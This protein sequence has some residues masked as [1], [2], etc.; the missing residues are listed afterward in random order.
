MASYWATFR[1]KGAGLPAAGVGPG[2]N[3]GGV[4]VIVATGVFPEAG[5]RLFSS[6]ANVKCSLLFSIGFFTV[7]PWLHFLQPPE[8]DRPR[9]ARSRR[10]DEDFDVARQGKPCQTLGHGQFRV[11]GSRSMVP[12]RQITL[13]P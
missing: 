7:H 8:Q 13:G 6:T 11:P 5:N 9:H 3:V 4:G 10:A 1:R 2:V 12:M